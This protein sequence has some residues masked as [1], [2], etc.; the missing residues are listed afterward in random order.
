MKKDING[1]EYSEETA[2]LIRN[3]TPMS[4]EELFAELDKWFIFPKKN[5]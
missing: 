5:K 4:F 2:E 3:S 1:W